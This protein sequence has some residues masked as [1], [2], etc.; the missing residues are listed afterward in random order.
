VAKIYINGV[1]RASDTIGGDFSNWDGDF[2]LALANELTKDRPWLGEFHL[3]AIYNRALSQTE[4]SQNF[5][6]RLR[7]LMP[8]L[9]LPLIL[10]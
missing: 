3:V 9:W 6:A 10:K 2:H 1:E 8:L 7:P 5:R 4:V